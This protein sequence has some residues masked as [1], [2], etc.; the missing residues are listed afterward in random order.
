[1]FPTL[2]YDNSRHPMLERALAAGS[3]T[4]VCQSVVRIETPEAGAARGVTPVTS[5]PTQFPQT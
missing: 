2:A 3:L 5:L 1:M 4:P